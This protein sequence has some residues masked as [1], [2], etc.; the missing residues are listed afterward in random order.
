MDFELEF[1]VDLELVLYNNIFFEDER[2]TDKGHFEV[3][4]KSVGTPSSLD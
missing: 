3:N 2:L 1:E 4:S